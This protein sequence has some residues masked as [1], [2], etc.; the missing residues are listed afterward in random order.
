[1]SAVTVYFCQKF[2]HNWFQSRM[3]LIKSPKSVQATQ[4]HLV[5]EKHLLH[6]VKKKQ[7]K[8]DKQAQAAS[9]LTSSSH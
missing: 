5:K 9:S 8:R 7:K 6:K 3:K 1:M 4:S 2:I